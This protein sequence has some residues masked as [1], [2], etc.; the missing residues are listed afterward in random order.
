MNK[1]TQ[2]SVNRDTSGRFLAGNKEGGRKALPPE[3]KLRIEELAPR[4][5]ERLAE[6][7]LSEDGQ[8]AARACSLILDRAYG[9]PQQSVDLGGDLTQSLADLAQRVAVRRNGHSD[10]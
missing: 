5:I 9:K 8:V 7:M 3:L 6:L 2:G 4:A 10:S 1:E